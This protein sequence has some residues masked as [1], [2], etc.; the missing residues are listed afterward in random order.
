[1]KDSLSEPRIAEG[2]KK[3]GTIPMPEVDLGTLIRE[4]AAYWEQAIRKMGIRIE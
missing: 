2:L 4:Y 1:L 3:L